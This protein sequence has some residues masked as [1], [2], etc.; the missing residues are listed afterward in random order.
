MTDTVSLAERL[1]EME[2]LA[3][4]R[5][6][7]GD[8][9]GYLEISASD[10]VYFDPFQERR[11]DG[12]PALSRVYEEIRGKIK[13]SSFEILNPLIQEMGDGAVLTYNLV[14]HPERSDQPLHWNATE[15]FRRDPRGRWWLVHSHW[16]YAKAPASA[17]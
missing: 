8:P 3:L 16:S 4:E 15:V 11:V 12:L 17:A 13:I 9:S 5:W 2:R 10:V 7:R 6:S 14:C 1:Q